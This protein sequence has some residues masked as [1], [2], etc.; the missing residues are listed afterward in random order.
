MPEGQTGKSKPYVAHITMNLWGCD[1]LQQWKTD[2]K[3]IS[4]ISETNYKMRNAYGRNSKRYYQG[5]SQ[6]IRTVHKQGIKAVG[7]SMVLT[8]LPL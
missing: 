6:T 4:P 3:K 7:I 5:Q 8:A 1:L 2:K